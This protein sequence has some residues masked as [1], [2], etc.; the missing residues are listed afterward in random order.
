MEALSPRRILE[1]TAGTASSSAVRRLVFVVG[2]DGSGPAR[3]ALEQAEEL[4]RN[5]EGSLEVVYV[6]DLPVGAG[7][8]APAPPEVLHGFDEKHR[9][10][11]E[12]VRGRLV[13]DDHPWHFQRRAGSVSAELLAVA[14]DLQ[15]QK[16]VLAKIP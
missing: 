9:A 15:R 6:A 3:R 12:E 13:G 2:F 1:T 8:S 14:T 10:L 7:L 16:D 5:R 11:A 4:L